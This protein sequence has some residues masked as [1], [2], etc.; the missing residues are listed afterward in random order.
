MALPFCLFYVQERTKL[1]SKC[2]SG[3]MVSPTKSLPCGVNPVPPISLSFLCQPNGSLYLRGASSSSKQ[4]LNPLCC[5]PKTCRKNQL[6][7]YHV[8]DFSTSHQ[9]ARLQKLGCQPRNLFSKL[10]GS[11]I[12]LAANSCFWEVSPSWNTYSRLNFNNADLSSLFSSFFLLPP[13]YLPIL[14]LLFC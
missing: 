12:S 6:I 5:F 4:Q 1:P 11:A 8:I 10:T 14:F 2:N 13:W 3:C 7:T 9:E